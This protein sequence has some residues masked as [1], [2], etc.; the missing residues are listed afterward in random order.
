MIKIHKVFK[1]RPYDHLCILCFSGGSD[2]KESAY[3]TWDYGS[4]PGSGIC[5]GEE[6]GYP[7]QYSC[8]EN[9]MNRGAFVTMGSQRV[10]PNWPTEH[11]HTY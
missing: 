6:N 11:T 8:L 1:H 7:F 10:G 5:P 2:S 3:N 9:S 4:I